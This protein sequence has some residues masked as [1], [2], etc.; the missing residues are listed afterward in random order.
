M[1]NS[2]AYAIIMTIMIM[3]V[4]WEEHQLDRQPFNANVR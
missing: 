2:S 1:E 4:T 3:M